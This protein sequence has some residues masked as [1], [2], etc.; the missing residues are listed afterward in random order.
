MD[1]M[2]TNIEN[3]ITNEKMDDMN[4]FNLQQMTANITNL[5][6]KIN[7]LTESTNSNS[8]DISSL[9]DTVE[10]IRKRGLDTQGNHS[11]CSIKLAMNQMLNNV[12]F[13]NIYSLLKDGIK[14]SPFEFNEDMK[15]KCNEL[16]DNKIKN[17]LEKIKNDNQNMWINAVELTQKLNKPGEIKEII[18]KVPPTI[19]PVD[20]SIKR[21]LDVDYYNGKNSSPKVPDL[22]S[23]LKSME[24]EQDENPENKEKKE[25]EDNKEK[26]KDNENDLVQIVSSP[27]SNSATN[28]M[29]GKNNGENEGDKNS[30]SSSKKDKNSKGSKNSKNSKNSKGS[31]NSSKKEANSL[32]DNNSKNESENKSGNNDIK[33]ENS[34]NSKVSKKS[35]KKSNSSKNKEVTNTNN[36][37]EEKNNKENGNEEE[38]GEEEGGEEEGDEEEGGE[39]EDGEEEGNNES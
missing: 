12:E 37:D 14:N 4:K 29:F 26:E 6:S 11:T 32:G 3:E 23:R 38:G 1:V 27:D 35:D 16:I 31:K 30:K 33:S 36:D 25:T 8:T 20:D 34:K 18:D 2:L 17:E 5:K 9:K 15:A 21:L 7:T 19:L 28:K 10:M 24:S 22:E 13:S 39:E